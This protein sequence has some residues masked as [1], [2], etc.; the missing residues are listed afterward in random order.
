MPEL[1]EGDA[2][3]ISPYIFRCALDKRD[4]LAKNI[5]EDTATYLAT[6]IVNLVNLFNP[7]IVILGGEFVRDNHFLLSKVR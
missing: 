6:G 1:A 5:T 4:Q 7:E 3:R 2:T